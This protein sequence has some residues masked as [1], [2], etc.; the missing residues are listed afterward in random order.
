[1]QSKST[2]NREQTKNSENIGSETDCESEASF[3]DPSV[4]AGLYR[5]PAHVVVLAVGEGMH[6]GESETDCE[7]SKGESQKVKYG[8]FEDPFA[9]HLYALHGTSARAP[10]ALLVGRARQKPATRGRT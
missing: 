7:S 2:S 10:L 8:S 1:M 4:F 5:V 3:E 9:L 6:V